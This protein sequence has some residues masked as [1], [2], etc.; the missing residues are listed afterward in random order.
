[1]PA[2]F[3]APHRQLVPGRCPRPLLALLLALAALA[4]AGCVI[5]KPSP[6]LSAARRSFDPKYNDWNM[7]LTH[8]VTPAGVDYA[9]LK[10]DKADG[11]L[12]IALAEMS[13]VAPE[14]FAEWSHD[15]QL[16]FLIN[17]HNAQAMNRVL[18]HYPVKSL[19][20][21]VSLLATARGTRNIHLLGREWSLATLADEITGYP[22]HESRALF[23]LNW[24]AK[25]CAPLPGVAVTASNLQD[26]LERQTADFMTD[27]KNSQYDQKSHIVYVSRL[28]SW[29]SDAFDRDFQ[30]RWDFVKRR[31][32]KSEMDV[33]NQRKQ[34]PRLRYLPFD[35]SLNDASANVK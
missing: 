35:K 12:E 2:G 17:A 25:G 10:S 8:Y 21:T 7:I 15:T 20:E 22:Y 18:R 9:R 4:G 11:L 24:A 32:P 3:I 14:Q 26:L 16:A 28:I 27:P 31:L 6:A 34:P 5:N 29:Y 19:G 13:L 23:L 30:S 1:M 33:V